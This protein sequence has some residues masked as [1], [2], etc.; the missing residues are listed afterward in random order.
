[1]TCQYGCGREAKFLLVFKTIENKWCC[2]E[3]WNS[4][5]AQIERQKY[6][7]LQAWN[8]DSKLLSKDRNIKISESKRDLWSNPNSVYNSK[9]FKEKNRINTI[10]YFKNERNR[11]KLSEQI[12]RLWKNKDY[13]RKR[14]ISHKKAMSKSSVKDKLKIRMINEWNNPN[15][16]YNSEN[17]KNKIRNTMIEKFKDPAYLKKFQSGLHTKPNNYEKI[18][19]SILPESYEY[20]GNYSLWI[21][22]KNPDFI[23]KKEMKII[24]FFGY[25]HH[26]EVTGIKNEDHERDRIEHFEKYGYRC[27]V[28]WEKD[29]YDITKLKNM[30]LNF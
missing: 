7:M 6:K 18:I 23:N 16:I 29:L 28:I 2:S 9:D 8:R 20:T 24:E 11:K 13:V 14:N 25:Y 27:L 10:N 5:P 26:E 3:K 30:I 4:C 19:I 21:G 22:G 1:M 15:S 12:S 17:V